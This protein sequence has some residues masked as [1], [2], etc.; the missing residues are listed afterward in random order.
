MTGGRRVMGREVVGERMFGVTGIR[1]LQ[2]LMARRSQDEKRQVSKCSL[3]WHRTRP[4]KEVAERKRVG[5]VPTEEVGRVVE[6]IKEMSGYFKEDKRR[7][8]V[9]TSKIFGSLFRQVGNLLLD[10][11]RKAGEDLWQI[12]RTA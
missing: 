4:D 2:Q 9:E 3:L 7:E 5:G 12:W 11:L 1:T 8:M 10:L 6:G